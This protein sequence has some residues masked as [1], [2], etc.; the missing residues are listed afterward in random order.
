MLW[1]LLILIIV[2]FAAGG[3]E[4]RA[5][6]F[7]LYHLLWELV[8]NLCE[9]KVDVCFLLCVEVL[10]KQEVQLVQP[11]G[12]QK[13]KLHALDFLSQRFARRCGYVHRN[14]PYRLFH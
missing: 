10:A 1:Y 13:N 8:L 5:Y 3:T 14:Q 12:L 6:W 2:D 4:K 9:P 11:C 7:L